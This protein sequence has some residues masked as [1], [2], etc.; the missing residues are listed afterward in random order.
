MNET[1]GQTCLWLVRPL[2]VRDGHR[3]T[4]KEDQ[5]VLLFPHSPNTAKKSRLLSASKQHTFT[6]FYP[7]THWHLSH[8][9]SMNYKSS[10]RT[11]RVQFSLEMLG[12]TLSPWQ[13]R[14]CSFATLPQQNGE[15]Y[16]KDGIKGNKEGE[17]KRRGAA[18][19]DFCQKII[20]TRRRSKTIGEFP[21]APTITPRNKRH[22]KEYEAKENKYRGNMEEA[23][24][25]LII[26]A[27]PQV[28][29]FFNSSAL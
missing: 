13:D 11:A 7:R 2:R 22:N 20:E 28:T 4:F 6:F 10:V 16:F 15:P 19:W 12:Q 21:P 18:K 8:T 3:W 26:R 1:S 14:H 25:G 29:I 24:C 5:I 9:P 17:N 27:T 23:P